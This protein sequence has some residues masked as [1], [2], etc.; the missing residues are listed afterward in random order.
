MIVGVKRALLLLLTLA[1]CARPNDRSPVGGFA[2]AAAMDA[3][4]AYVVGDLRTIT[5]LKFGSSSP[6]WRIE[7]RRLADGLPETSFGQN[8]VVFVKPGGPPRAIV[9]DATSMYVAGGG[10]SGFWRIEKRSL[11]TGA[12]DPAFGS[13]GIVN[14]AAAGT[15]RASA[16]DATHLYLVGVE[17]S[18]ADTQWRIEK[19]LLADGSLEAAFGTAG[20][21]TVNPSGG[22]DIP[23]SIAISATSMIVAGTDAG[24]DGARQRIEK[25]SLADGSPDGAFGAGGALVV[26]LPGAETIRDVGLDATSIY[27]G[28]S[29]GGQWRLEKRAL[30]DGS[31]DAAFGVGGVIVQPLG[32]FGSSVT[33]IVMEGAQFYAIGYE[34]LIAAPLAESLW[35]IEK[36]NVADG[37]MVGTFGTAGVVSRNRTP[38]GDQPHDATV[39]AAGLLV[40][41]ESAPGEFPWQMELFTPATGA[42]IWAQ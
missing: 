2:R 27:V 36:R 41:G 34:D 14:G 24:G 40:V 26:D 1:G 5:S 8:G 28:G 19:R 25:R 35:R 32:G 21:V 16:A 3:A 22:G 33:S 6:Q 13:S 10:S 31:L 15:V 7:K 4:H 42:S 30:S 23:R 20:A 11:A 39:G 17:G 9:L 37:S 18:G 38:W 12:L 29:D